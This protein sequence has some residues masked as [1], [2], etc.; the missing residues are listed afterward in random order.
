MLVRGSPYLCGCSICFS[1]GPQQP[2]LSFFPGLIEGFKVE[3]ASLQEALVQKETSEQGLV[4]ELESLKQQLQ[5][6]TRQQA[7]L[8][9]ENAVLCHQKEVAATEAE[10]RE[11][12]KEG[13]LQGWRAEHGQHHSRLFWKRS[14]PFLEGGEERW[15]YFS[16]GTWECVTLRGV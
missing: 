2:C 10:E 11:A 13:C 9:E 12:G 4:A 5:R 3:K 6:V 1:R 16:K 8:K 7:E 15:R 14:L